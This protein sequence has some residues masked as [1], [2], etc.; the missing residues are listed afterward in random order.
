MLD[1]CEFALSQAKSLGVDE[2]E[3]YAESNRIIRIVIQNNSIDLARS[4]INEGIGIRAFKRYGL[5]YASCNSLLEGDVKTTVKNAISF[6][7]AALRDPANYLPS[8]QKIEKFNIFDPESETFCMENGLE[9]AVRLLDSARKD[10]RV[11]ID[12]GG[13]EATIQKRAI[14]SSKGVREEES[15]NYFV[16]YLMGMARE[17]DRVSSFDLEFDATRWVKEIDVERIGRSLADKVLASL[18]AEKGKCFKGSILLSPDA[19]ESIVIRPLIS[20]V[21]ANNVQKGMSRFVGKLGSSVASSLF[22]LVDNGTIKGGIG[23]ESFDREGM[24]HRRLS[25]IEKGVLSSFMYNAYA[26][27]REGRDTTGH[28]Q[29]GTRSVPRIGPTNMIVSPGDTAK[30]DI[31]REIKQGVIVTRFSGFPNPITG[32]FSGVVKGGF[33]IENGR[34]IKP[35]IGTLISGNIY[36]GLKNISAISK[37]IKKLANFILPYVR[38]DNISVTSR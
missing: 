7:S 14:A 38:I 8:Q 36:K 11:S 37:E 20:A 32:D 25:L 5:G 29:G 28:A 31:I 9:F 34:V 19:V 26:A 33:L 10:K 12:S 23:T 4:D 27:N 24:P 1:T 30:D 2:A 35:L 3:V 13:F 21:N 17:K 6:A 18:G 15:L 22:T 16:Y